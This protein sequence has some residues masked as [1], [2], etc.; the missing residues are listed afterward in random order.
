MDSDRGRFTEYG[1]QHFRELYDGL[2][3]R[4]KGKNGGDLLYDRYRNG[5]LHGLGPKSGFALCRDEELD[6]AYVGD[7]EVEVAQF[8]G[9]NVDRLAADFLKLVG[10]LAGGAA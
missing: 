9:I 3:N 8:V 6:G 1:R 4:V 2:S 5:L 7:V 10:G